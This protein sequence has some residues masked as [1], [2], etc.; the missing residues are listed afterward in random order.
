MCAF[1]FQSGAL[2][3]LWDR[4][5]RKKRGWDFIIMD[6]VSFRE[7]ACRPWR[8]ANRLLMLAAGP[9]TTWVISKKKPRRKTK[10]NK[11]P[12]V[13]WLPYFMKYYIHNYLAKPF[14]AVS[15][16]N[17]AKCQFLV[18]SVTKISSKQ[19][20]PFQRFNPQS[21]RQRNALRGLRCMLCFVLL[22]SYY[23]FHI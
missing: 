15:D 18:Q 6:F 10:Q 14:G 22:W 23:Q 13:L 7:N 4:S 5:I 16:D 1:L 11:K 9:R 20:N 12:F 21:L 17:F 2:W 3:D 8:P 19:T